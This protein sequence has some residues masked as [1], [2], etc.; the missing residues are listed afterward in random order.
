MVI[1]I[2]V[3]LIYYESNNY[4]CVVHYESKQQPKNIQNKRKHQ[5]KK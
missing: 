1:K 5:L 2:I 3:I 4:V